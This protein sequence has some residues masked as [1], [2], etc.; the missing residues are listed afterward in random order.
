MATWSLVSLSHHVYCTHCSAS[1]VF[2]H[3]EH[4]SSH[5][6]VSLYVSPIALSGGGMVV[7]AVLHSPSQMPPTTLEILSKVWKHHVKVSLRLYHFKF[8]MRWSYRHRYIIQA[9]Y[10]G[11]E[12]ICRACACWYLN[13]Y[14][15]FLLFRLESGRITVQ[16]SRLI[17]VFLILFSILQTI[18]A[19]TVL[20]IPLYIRLPLLSLLVT[21]DMLTRSSNLS[22]RTSKKKKIRSFTRMLYVFILIKHSL[23]TYLCCYNFYP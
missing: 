9:W 8:G 1:A 12:A 14:K 11:T 10:L 19:F 7:T 17:F 13:S 22:I 23:I 3:H 4:F 6:W 18:T 5:L 16:S 2:Y 15:R 21:S 20:S